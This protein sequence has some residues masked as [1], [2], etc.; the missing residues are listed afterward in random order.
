MKNMKASMAN[1]EGV[2]AMYALQD[3][4]NKYQWYFYEVYNNDD[5]Y[6]THCNTSHFKTYINETTDMLKEKLLLD[7]KNDVM[8]TQGQLR[9]S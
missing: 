1:E 9:F 4:Q 5:A 8:V 3:K 6:T 7:L 2:L